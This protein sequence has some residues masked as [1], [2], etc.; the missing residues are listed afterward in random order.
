MLSKSRYIQSEEEEKTSSY[1]YS[2]MALKRDAVH[3]F[4]FYLLQIKHDRRCFKVLM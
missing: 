2:N 4:I 3:L 1:N